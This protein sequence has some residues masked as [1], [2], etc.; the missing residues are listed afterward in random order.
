MKDGNQIDQVF[1]MDS[2]YRLQGDSKDFEFLT[3][4]IGFNGASGNSSSNIRQNNGGLNGNDKKYN[5]NEGLVNPNL[6]G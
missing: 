3:S 5:Q 1:N 4:Q 2:N 6:V